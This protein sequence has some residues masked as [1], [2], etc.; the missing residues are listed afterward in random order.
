MVTVMGGVMARRISAGMVVVVV[1]VIIVR[2]SVDCAKAESRKGCKNAFGDGESRSVHMLNPTRWVSNYSSKSGMDAFG[3]PISQS[4]A[5]ARCISGSERE[6]GAEFGAELIGLKS[7]AFECGQRS[8]I[9]I[10]ET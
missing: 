5:T 7:Y 2:A 6:S 9:G 3:F 1:T 8:H 4:G 10:V